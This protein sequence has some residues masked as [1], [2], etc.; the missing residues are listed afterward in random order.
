MKMIYLAT[1]PQ[2][3]QK[4]LQSAAELGA[5][6]WCGSDAISEAEFNAFAGADVSRFNYSLGDAS[7]DVLAGAIDTIR[8]HHPDSTIWVEAKA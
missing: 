6:V 7:E 8:E 4:A 5:A 2:G 1:T 3:L